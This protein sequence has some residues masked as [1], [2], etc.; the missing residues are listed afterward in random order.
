MASFYVEKR[1]GEKVEYDLSRIENAITK[2]NESLDSTKDGKISKTLIKT[3]TNDVNETIMSYFESV[4]KE[5]DTLLS[6]INKRLF[7][8]ITFLLF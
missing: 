7:W 4:E 1:D 2:A 6:K 3:I 8:K 5:R